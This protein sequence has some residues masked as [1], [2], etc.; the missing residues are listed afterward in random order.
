MDAEIMVPLA[1]YGAQLL[2]VSSESLHATR[3]VSSLNNGCQREQNMKLQFTISS[4]CS[5]KHLLVSKASMLIISLILTSR[6]LGGWSY[7]LPDSRGACW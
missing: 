1:E 4:K 3:V 2:L 6:F 7:F 5:F